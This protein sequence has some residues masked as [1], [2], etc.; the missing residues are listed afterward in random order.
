MS[1]LVEYSSKCTEMVCYNKHCR[2]E[3]SFFHHHHL[4]GYKPLLDSV[5]PGWMQNVSC[6]TMQTFKLQKEKNIVAE[7]A[8]FV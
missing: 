8:W 1:L 2:N 7:V 3:R 4:R 6:T 5:G